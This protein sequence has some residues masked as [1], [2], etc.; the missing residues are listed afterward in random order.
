M[1]LHLNQNFQ[2]LLL[3]L[4]K[5]LIDNN[6]VDYVA[7][8]IKNDFLNYDKTSGI[9]RI[10]IENIKRS[11][12]ILESS[13]IE[14]EFRTTVV[15]ELHDLFGLEEICKYFGPNVKYYIQNY[16]DCNTVLQNGLSGFAKEELL[17]IEAHLKMLNPNVII[18]GI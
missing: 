3:H 5:H 15:R 4:I 7:M 18:R 10:N 12:S 17:N 16:K 9:E 6:L 1:M 11:I 13:N 8:D 2:W 14:Y